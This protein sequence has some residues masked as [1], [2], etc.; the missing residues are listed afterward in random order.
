MFDSF[1]LV[2]VAFLLLP[3]IA[4]VLVFNLT[5]FLEPDGPENNADELFTLF[6]VSTRDES[7]LEAK[8]D[9]TGLVAPISISRIMSLHLLDNDL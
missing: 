4:G 1:K 9:A 8:G 2:F 6:G 7:E 5:V 3:K